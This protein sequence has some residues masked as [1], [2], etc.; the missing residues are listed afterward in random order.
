MIELNYR[1]L[2]RRKYSLRTDCLEIA[3]FVVEIVVAQITFIANV[4]RLLV[5]VLQIAEPRE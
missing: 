1:L 2:V 5:H 4:L 3:V